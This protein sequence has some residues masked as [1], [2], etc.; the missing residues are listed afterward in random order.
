MN[1][2]RQLPNWVQI[3]RDSP[4]ESMPWFKLDLDPDVDAALTRLNLQTGTVLD[5][6]TGPGTQ[7]IELAQR[8]FQVTATDISDAAIEGAQAKAT[9]Q[10]L[11]ISWQQ[12]DI[13]NSKI[14]GE[15]DLILDRGCFHGF[16]LAQRQKYLQFIQDVSKS[17]GYLF[18][19]CFSHLETREA[20]PYRFSPAE[21]QE[22]FSDKFNLIF[23]QETLYYGTLDPLPKALFCVMQKP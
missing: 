18:L 19:K 17:G 2:E 20:G 21:I 12:D 8:G 16:H 13:L 22:M 15:F 1:Q 4:V 23:I 7:A 6:G 11:N 14:R 9:A 3:Y 5:I 10:G